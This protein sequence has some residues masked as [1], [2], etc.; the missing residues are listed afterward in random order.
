MIYKLSTDQVLVTMKY[1]LVP[2]PI[3]L[4]EVTNK[5]DS[6]NKKIQVDIVN[7]EDSIVQGDHSNNN[8]DDGQTQFKDKDSSIDKSHCKSD[9]SQQLKDLTSNK[10]VN[11]ENQIILSKEQNNFTIISVNTHTRLT[12]TSTSIQGF[13]TVSTHNRNCYFM[14]MLSLWKYI[15]NHIPI[16]IVIIVSISISTK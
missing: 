4:I 10:I 15:Y 7:S 16:I 3:D 5:M 1:Q 8:K 11:Q 12:S 6:S 14:P 2:V 9:S 13:F